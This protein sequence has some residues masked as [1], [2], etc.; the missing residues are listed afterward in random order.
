MILLLRTFAA[1]S[2]VGAVG[3][4]AAAV[5]I[6]ALPS[7]GMGGA[8]LATASA[9]SVLCLVLFGFSRG[10]S[11]P[12]RARSPIES[13]VRILASEVAGLFKDNKA[14]LLLAALVCG[15]FAGQR[16]G[17]RRQDSL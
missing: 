8:A 4:V 15:V 5:W 13:D 2:A 10:L 17:L 14:A 1:F 12:I 11:R 16:N 7:L 9:L 3:S 6:Y